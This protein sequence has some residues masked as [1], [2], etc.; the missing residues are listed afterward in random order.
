MKLPGL[1]ILFFAIMF[2]PGCQQKP[3]TEAPKPVNFFFTEQTMIQAAYHWERVANEVSHDI[4]TYT[5]A[6]DYCYD[7]YVAP[8]NRSSF[9]MAYREYLKSKLT[10]KCFAI[11][12]EDDCTLG[13]EIRTQV[14]HHPSFPVDTGYRPNPFNKYNHLEQHELIVSNDLYYNNRIIGT[15][16]RTLYFRDDEAVNYQHGVPTR[17]YNVIGKH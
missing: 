16:T 15:I 11:C 3:F 12:V 17:T 14:V 10:K 13:L 5:D 9:E 6:G 7:I 2:F 1:I 8:A 4:E